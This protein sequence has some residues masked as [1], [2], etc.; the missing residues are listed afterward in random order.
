MGEMNAAGSASSRQEGLAIKAF[1]TSL[2]AENQSAT[3]LLESIP[4][5]NGQQA[6]K[7]TPGA[8]AGQ[9]IDIIV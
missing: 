4:E 6:V 3:Q 1:K 8:E 2:S 7:P 9:Q 5:S